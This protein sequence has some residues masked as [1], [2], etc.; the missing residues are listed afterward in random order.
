MA[1]TKALAKTS[2]R[3]LITGGTGFLGTHIVRNL[4]D[5]G[6]TN[7][8][9][10]ASRVPQWMTDAG[11]E[12]V[13]GSITNR[14]DVGEACKNVSAIFHLAGKVSRDNGDASAMNRI[15]L[16]GTRLLCDAAREA[17]VAAMILASSSGTI[18]VT[19]TPE[20]V[21]ETFPQ[22]VSIITRWAYY[23]SKYY[24]ERAAI[25]NFAGDRRRL[26]IL[27]PSLLLG[28]GDERLSST[29]PVL[30]FLA[31]KIPYSPSGGLSFVDVRDAASAFIAALEK[32]RDGEKYL[33]GAA[34]MKFSEFFSR[35]E[36]L[37]GVSAP[38]L[39]VPKQLA[40]AGSSIISS[41]YKNWGKAS[42]V[43]PNEVE[44]A[45]HFWYFDSSKAEVELGFTPRDPQE[46][47]QDTIS[48]I[49]RKF[50]GDGVFQ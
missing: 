19:E 34:N 14:Q 23:A 30:D 24:Q 35:L 49:R 21:D 31:R 39:T 26:V 36:R 44:Q 17:G 9:V 13:E 47:L 41:I 12:S 7:L 3:I 25:E 32:G 37:S 2:K 5:A 6:E 4:L 20:T 38:M 18:A 29:K 15:H 10:M 11:I 22:P 33:V 16:E 46:T 27:N 1:K 40:M 8:R 48:Y 42:P 45:E 28:P 50:L 43:A